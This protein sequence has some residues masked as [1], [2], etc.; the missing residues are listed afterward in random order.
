MNDGY[1]LEDEYAKNFTE[2]TFQNDNS[3]L[4]A[5]IFGSALTFSDL[6]LDEENKNPE[7]L[8]EDI[9]ALLSDREPEQLVEK[10]NFKRGT[11]TGLAFE[12]YVYSK[13]KR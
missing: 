1:L 7:D 2:D 12:Q 3:V 9:E 10:I 13:L 6:L 4:E 5:A 11:Q 8:L